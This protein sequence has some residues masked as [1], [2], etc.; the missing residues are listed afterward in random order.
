MSIICFECAK[1]TSKRS[2]DDG[3]NNPKPVAPTAPANTIT[4]ASAISSTDSAGEEDANG[5]TNSPP[6][7]TV[8]KI[9]HYH[10]QS[11]WTKHFLDFIAAFPFYLFLHTGVYFIPGKR[12]V[13]NPWLMLRFLRFGSFATHV[14]RRVGMRAATEAQ[15]LS[16]QVTA[17]SA[18]S[19]VV[20][21]MLTYKI[22]STNFDVDFL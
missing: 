11:E 14:M 20:V 17:Y 5:A 7:P 19:V 10:F 13:P 4:T 9:V 18:C 15:K 1:S 16:A 8:R 22:F 21:H 3:I 6:K 12:A 2:P